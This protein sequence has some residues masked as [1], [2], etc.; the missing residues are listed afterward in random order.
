MKE[1]SGLLVLERP[2][3]PSASK[4]TLVLSLFLLICLSLLGSL[5]DIAGLECFLCDRGR[6]DHG[7]HVAVF[8]GTRQEGFLGS[9]CDGSSGGGGAGGGGGAFLEITITL[10]FPWIVAFCTYRLQVLGASL[11]DKIF[12]DDIAHV[13][14]SHDIPVHRHSTVPAEQSSDMDLGHEL[15]ADGTFLAGIIFIDTHNDIF[16]CTQL[17]GVGCKQTSRVNNGI[18]RSFDTWTH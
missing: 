9:R 17:L 14:S 15:M 10:L 3:L 13:V 18:T 12:F 11:V 1:K 6:G 5:S 8:T 2:S 16:Q 4:G 7:L